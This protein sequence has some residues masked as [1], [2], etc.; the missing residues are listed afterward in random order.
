MNLSESVTRLVE[1]EFKKRDVEKSVAY[2]SGWPIG[3]LAAGRYRRELESI[4]AEISSLKAEMADA[5]KYE[6]G[7]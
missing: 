4:N 5:N 1:L 6:G 2:Y 3:G 7:G